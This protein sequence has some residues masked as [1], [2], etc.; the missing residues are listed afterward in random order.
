MDGYI[1]IS[2]TEEQLKQVRQLSTTEGFVEAFYINDRALQ[3]DGRLRY[4][5]IAAYEQLEET[6][7]KLF[8]D[9]KYA[10]YPQFS[11]ARRDIR[12]EQ[13]EKGNKK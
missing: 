8:G 2:F 10:G 6:H 9:R 12:A 5:K 11:R 4:T 13:I 3:Q 1:L 7:C